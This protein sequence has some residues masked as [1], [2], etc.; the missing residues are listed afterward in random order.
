M[1]LK[2]NLALKNRQ[3]DEEAHDHDDDDDNTTASDDAGKPREDEDQ[4]WKADL[5]SDHAEE[6][7]LIPQK[8]D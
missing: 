4:K 5:V 1:N 8:I 3:V 6:K 7:I 2:R